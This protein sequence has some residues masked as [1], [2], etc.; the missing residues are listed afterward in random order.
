MSDTPGGGR[1]S[2]GRGAGKRVVITG[3]GIVSPVGNDVDTAWKALLAGTSG[4]GPITRFETSELYSTRIACE[5]KGF[6]PLNHLDA[7][8][9]RRYD[10]YAQF[11]V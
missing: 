8:E 2:P 9:A 6:E 1:S 4:G 10:R 5:V 7:K 11:A 3:L